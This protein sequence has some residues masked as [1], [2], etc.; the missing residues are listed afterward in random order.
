[1]KRLLLMISVMILLTLGLSA[2]VGSTKASSNTVT[3]HANMTEFAY[4]PSTWT[5]PA[6]KEVSIVLQNSGTTAHTWT[7]MSKPVSGSYTSADQA[8][9]LFDSGPVAPGSSKT[10][11]FTAPA[12]PG[13]YQVICTQPG[14][15]E[16]GMAGQLTVQ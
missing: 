11:S 9:V 1:M 8:N 2:C 14:H 13:T 5:V 6:G 4:T 3:L 12:T 16:A 15:F 7:V 10:V